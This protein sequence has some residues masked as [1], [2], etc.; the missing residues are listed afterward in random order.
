MAWSVTRTLVQQMWD[1]L[2]EEMNGAMQDIP[3]TKIR[4]RAIAECVAIF[5]VPFF[6]TADEVAKEALKRYKAK[7]AG[8][9]YETPGIG[10]RK[11]ERPGLESK[12]D[13]WYKSPDGGFTSDA[14][15]AGLPANKK[16]GGGVQTVMPLKIEDIKL[17]EK[18][19]E[20]IRYMHGSG[21]F[22]FEVL[23][24]TYGVDVKIIKFIVELIPESTA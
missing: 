7:Q 21:M 20:A 12:Y 23:A 24:T 17:T 22:P 18:E 8:E 13:G 9:E 10:A 14:A 1:L 4:A 16:R 6:T 3:G 2:D 19:Q 15:Q 5:M 11:Y